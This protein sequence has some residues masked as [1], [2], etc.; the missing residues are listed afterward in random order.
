MHFKKNAHSGE[1]RLLK[2][3]A[4][5]SLWH[6]VAARNGI[7]LPGIAYDYLV[8][9]TRPEAAP[10][11]RTRH[12]WLSL[13]AD[14]RAYRD[15]AGRRELGALRWLASPVRHR[16]VL[17]SWSDPGPFLSSSLARIKRI[18]R[19]TGRLWRWRSTAS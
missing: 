3:N 19:L 7:N 9:G 1:W 5:F 11:Y 14:Y 17:F 8:H 12:R 18:P 10:R 16:K 2:I 13:R 6:Y 15:L 4:R